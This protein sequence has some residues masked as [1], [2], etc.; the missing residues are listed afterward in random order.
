MSA[1]TDTTQLQIALRQAKIPFSIPTSLDF[2]AL[3]DSYN[4]LHRDRFPLLITRPQR[5][6]DVSTIVKKCVALNLPITIR[7]GGHDPFGRFSTPGTV[8]IDLRALN[9]VSVSVSDNTLRLGGGALAMQVIEAAEAHNLQVA[10]GNS[11]AVGYV[12]WCLLGGLGSWTSVFGLGS[13][14]IVNARV[15]NADG[16]L[17]D[18]DKQMLVGLRGGGGNLGI[19]VELVVKAYPLR[20][21][22]MGNMFF[23]MSDLAQAIST[24]LGNLNQLINK[25]QIPAHCDVHPMLMPIPGL[26]FVLFCSMTWNGPI[27]NTYYA[28]LDS[29]SKLGPAHETLPTIK[30]SM[31]VITP[32]GYAKKMGAILE[33]KAHGEA[34]ARSLTEF[35]SEANATIATCASEM[36]EQCNGGIALLVHR[37]TSPSCSEDA[38]PSVSPYTKPCIVV[39][40]I[41]Q[42]ATEQGGKI[43]VE[44][45]RKS[46]MKLAKVKGALLNSYLPLAAPDLNSL[47]GIYGEK[48]EKLRELKRKYDP[49]GIF[50]NAIPK[51]V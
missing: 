1:T 24:V 11:G 13:H 45:A 3:H 35:T 5:P 48:L 18:A 15:V 27:D 50:A 25:G 23:D 38:L 8:S 41:G 16:E 20:E 2:E 30:D 33:N 12:G 37:S 49:Q 19:V 7:G 43:A 44:W 40:F 9:S 29:V 46:A 10:F 36:P 34:H 14:Q 6:E 31:S 4:G 47:E 26:G 32:L 39:E 17:V 51:L 22:R 21:V 42:A 28:I